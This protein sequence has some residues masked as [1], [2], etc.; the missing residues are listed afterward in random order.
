MTKEILV[1]TFQK[2]SSLKLFSAWIEGF[3]ILVA[4]FICSF[5]AAGNDYQK[6]QQFEKLKEISKAKKLVTKQYFFQ[7]LFNVG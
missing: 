3:S 1:N 6:Q 7:V 4:V 5:V 2:F